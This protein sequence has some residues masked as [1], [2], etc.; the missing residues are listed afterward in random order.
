M[1]HNVSF[2]KGGGSVLMG[3]FLSVFALVFYS[4]LGSAFYIN[5]GNVAVGVSVSLAMLIFLLYLFFKKS[6]AVRKSGFFEDESLNERDRMNAFFASA[7]HSV[8]F[9]GLKLICAYLIFKDLGLNVTVWELVFLMPLVFLVASLPITVWGLGTR[10]AA[11][12][13]LFGGLAADKL[14]AA[15]LVTAFA[16]NVFPVLL[17]LVFIKEILNRFAGLSIER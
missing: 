15:G 8:F 17:G 3:Y 12:L 2:P 7:A 4:A 6:P 11:A 16:C 10:E 1:R 5:S 9:E 13:F 14:V